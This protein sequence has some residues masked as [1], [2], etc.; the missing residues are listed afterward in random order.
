MNCH[1]YTSVLSPSGAF[2]EEWVAAVRTVI[3]VTGASDTYTIIGLAGHN[4][5]G[6]ARKEESGSDESLKLHCNE[7]RLHQQAHFILTLGPESEFGGRDGEK[8]TTKAH[9]LSLRP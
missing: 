5:T 3:V 2:V 7:G 6:K 1:T 4:S 9:S 8:I